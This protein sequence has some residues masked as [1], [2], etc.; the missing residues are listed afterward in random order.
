MHH[1]MC[2]LL[3]GMFSWTTFVRTDDL[4]AIRVQQQITW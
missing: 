1:L 4:E 3:V 2:D